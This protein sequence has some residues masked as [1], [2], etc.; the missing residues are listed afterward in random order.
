MLD[1]KS[2]PPPPEEE[3]AETMGKNVESLQ[4]SHAASPVGEWVTLS[5]RVVAIAPAR[6]TEPKHLIEIA[7]RARYR[8]Q[9]GG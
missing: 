6:D 1:E 4:I 9:A 7:D 3:V 2:V 8:A 5:L